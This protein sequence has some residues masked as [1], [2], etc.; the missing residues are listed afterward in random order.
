MVIY[1]IPHVSRH[2]LFCALLSGTF[3][4]FISKKRLDILLKELHECY[5]ALQLV[6]DQTKVTPRKISESTLFYEKGLHIH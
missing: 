1:T 3:L 5:A 4:R 6:N 2:G